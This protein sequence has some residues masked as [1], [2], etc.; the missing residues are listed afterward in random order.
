MKQRELFPIDHAPKIVR[1]HG[2]KDA[3]VYPLVSMGKLVSPYTSHRVT[4]E[5]AWDYPALEFRA[6]NSWPVLILDLDGHDAL[7]RLQDAAIRPY[8]FAV[9]RKTS[10]GVHAYWT[11]AR[12]VH[13]GESARRRPLA[14]LGRIS[15]FYALATKADSGFTHV[16]SHN[17]VYGESI[18]QPNIFQTYW[19]RKG[20]YSLTELA[21]PIPKGWRRPARPQTA[22]G[23]NVSLFEAGMKW[24]G[25]PENRNRSV[26]AILESWNEQLEIPLEHAEVSGIA[27]NVERYRR[28]WDRRGQFD[29][30]GDM[31][32]S[33]WGQSRGIRS[34]KARRART[35]DRN[36]KILLLRES[37]LKQW[38]I[39]EKFGLS[40]GRIAQIISELNR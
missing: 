27:K 1:E 4:P 15:E 21:E 25:S 2:L 30:R 29:A 36:E 17:P 10:G 8:S 23:R 33:L 26:L 7:D 38:Q 9:Q 34:G 14:L 18:F 6:G 16:L 35:R 13:R 39:A 37:G 22:V 12:P 31:E 5:E 28:Q 11:L 24:A 20:S 32:R 3:H 40:Q 19:N